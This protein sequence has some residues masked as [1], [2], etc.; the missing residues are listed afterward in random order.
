MGKPENGARTGRLAL[1]MTGVLAA[2]SPAN[3]ENKG[4]GSAP[5]IQYA[6]A[7]VE[8]VTRAECLALRT[9]TDLMKACMVKLADQRKI[10]I[11][12]I[13]KSIETEKEAND[14]R[15]TRVDVL[16]N[17][18]KEEEQKFDQ[19]VREEFEKGGQDPTR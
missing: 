15:N 6:S 18:V 4:T 1:L 2:C 10:E 17:E 7:N 12:A 14:Q 9:Q 8:T 5:E 3:A 13:D 19:M 16:S 11:A